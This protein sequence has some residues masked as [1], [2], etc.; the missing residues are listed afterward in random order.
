MPHYHPKKKPPPFSGK[1]LCFKPHKCPTLKRNMNWLR[2]RLSTTLLFAQRQQSLL[3][4]VRAF[5]GYSPGALRFQRYHDSFSTPE[6]GRHRVNPL[7]PKKAIRMMS[8]SVSSGEGSGGTGSGDGLRSGADV[9]TVGGNRLAGETSPY[10]LQHA[11]NPVDWMP[12]GEEAFRKARD[13][14][15]PIFLSIGYSTCHW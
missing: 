11:H 7:L 3:T 1:R 9:K 5:S 4:S 8:P 13:E 6:G 14:D 2:F 10:L 15:K 12:W